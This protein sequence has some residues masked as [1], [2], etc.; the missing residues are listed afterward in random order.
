LSV[1]RGGRRI[2]GAAVIK[3]PVT[4][5]CDNDKCPDEATISVTLMIETQVRQQDF[6]GVGAELVQAGFGYQ[7]GWVTY[8]GQV[9]C[10]Q[11]CAEAAP[12]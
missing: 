3:L 8:A 7:K 11:R 2:D 5:V 4:V 12:R 9:Y 1:V 6:Y 10:S